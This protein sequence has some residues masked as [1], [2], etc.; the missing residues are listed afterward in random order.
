MEKLVEK[1]IKWYVKV[2]VSELNWKWNVD[3]M[4][5]MELE[6]L[7]KREGYENWRVLIS[8]PSRFRRIQS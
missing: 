6:S 5:Y 2:E 8:S 7:I 1:P 4:S 3:Y